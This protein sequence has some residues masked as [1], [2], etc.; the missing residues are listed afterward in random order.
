MELTALNNIGKE[1]S[2]KL[3]QIGVQTAEDLQQ[4]GSKEAFVRLKMAFPE[5]CLV[6][7]YTLQGAIDGTDYNQLSE[8]LK[9]E[10]KGFSD[11][12]K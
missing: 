4:M 5:V 3:Q 6:H 10:L 7:L 2:R 11:G 1:M 9:A 8:E 12:L